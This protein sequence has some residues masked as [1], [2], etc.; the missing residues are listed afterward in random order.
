MSEHIKMPAAAPI[1]RY[2]ANGVDTIFEFPFPIFASE[3][4]AVY[5]G[6]ALQ[7][8]GYSVSGAGATAGGGVTFENAPASGSIVTLAREL[9][10]ERLTDLAESGA[11]WL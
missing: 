5:I 10:I 6:G 9:K 7:A 11:C 2:A 4:L 1:V 3:D 8:S